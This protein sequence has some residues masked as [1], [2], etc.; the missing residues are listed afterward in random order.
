MAG[1]K[2]GEA[3]GAGRRNRLPEQKPSAQSQLRCSDVLEQRNCREIAIAFTIRWENRLS[4]L[5]V[6]GVLSHAISSFR[7]SIGSIGSVPSDVMELLIAPC[8]EASGTPFS[9]KFDN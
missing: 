7:I 3:A 2:L 4:R 5:G 8:D 6:S 9:S 1:T